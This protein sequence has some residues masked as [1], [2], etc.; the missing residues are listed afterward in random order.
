MLCLSLQ[1]AECVHAMGR[2]LPAVRL[3]LGEIARLAPGLS[4]SDLPSAA[5]CLCCYFHFFFE[6]G[7]KLEF[8]SLDGEKVR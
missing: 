6:V 8:A 4:V 5:V 1:R 7:P 3:H 2:V